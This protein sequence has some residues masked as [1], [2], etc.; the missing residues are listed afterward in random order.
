M[1]LPQ[2][3]AK[4]A[5]TKHGGVRKAAKALKINYAVL[6]LLASGKRISASARTLR[7]LGLTKQVRAMP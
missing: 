4:A 5:I 1:T 2:E 6:S 7:A 3:R